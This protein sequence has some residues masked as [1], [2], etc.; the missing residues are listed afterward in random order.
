MAVYQSTLPFVTV[1]FRPV[2]AP[3][4]EVDARPFL[5]GSLNYRGVDYVGPIALVGGHEIQTYKL[6]D[7]SCLKYMER[8]SQDYLDLQPNDQKKTIFLQFSLDYFGYWK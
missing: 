1:E 2:C 6:E 4:G 5:S 3:Y 7:I 8:P